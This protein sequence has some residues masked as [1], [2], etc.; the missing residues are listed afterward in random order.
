MAGSSKKR[1]RLK[2]LDALLVDPM[3]LSEITSF[4]AGGHTLQEF[5]RTLDVPYNA[6]A[7]WIA[8]NEDRQRAYDASVALRDEHNKGVVVEQLCSMSTVDLADAFDPE[9]NCLLPMHK[10]PAQV[11]KA[12]AGVKVRELLASENYSQVLVGRLVDDL[13]NALDLSDEQVKKLR[14]FAEI[15]LDR[16]KIGEIIEIK[17]WDRNKATETLARSLKQLTDKTEVEGR[18]TLEQLVAASRI[19]PAQ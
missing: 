2:R 7:S 9:T 11:R 8:D 10:M 17:M 16:V 15:E 18:L 12:L 14:K 5:T 19:E 3:T 13:V 6:V 4:V 1:A